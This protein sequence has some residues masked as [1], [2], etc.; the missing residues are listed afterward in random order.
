MD[1]NDNCIKPAVW[2]LKIYL[3]RN[4]TI[5]NIYSSRAKAMSV[6]TEFN[7]DVSITKW[8]VK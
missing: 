4:W 6:A 2:V 7:I 5:F 1:H 3:R 8:M